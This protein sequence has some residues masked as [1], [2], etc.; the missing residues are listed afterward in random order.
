MNNF[1]EIKK[2][3]KFFNEKTNKENGSEKSVENDCNNGVENPKSIFQN[4]FNMQTNK[5]Y[6]YNDDNDIYDKMSPEK[7]NR[8]QKISAFKEI[9][10]PSTINKYTFDVNNNCSIDKDE[11]DNK[12]EN[13]WPEKSE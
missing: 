7:Q 11:N 12:N 10:N 6:K 3:T 2:E 5:E 1:D 4:N 13:K 8:L 9:N